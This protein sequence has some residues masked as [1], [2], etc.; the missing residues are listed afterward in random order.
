[1]A[2]LLLALLPL[3]ACHSS[4]RRVEGEMAA[5][6]A[7]A[8]VNNDRISYDEF[9]R[10]Y[11]AFLTHW[12]AF[13]LEEPQRKQEL[14]ELVLKQMI[15]ERLLDQEARRQGI[16]ISDA[17]VRTQIQALVSPM[18]ATDVR[19][20]AERAQRTFQDWVR[21]YQQR[22]VHQK[23]VQQEV[24]D[25]IN[26]PPR[27]VRDY[28]D[29]HLKQFFRPEQVHVRHIA[30]SNK[31]QYDRV[32]KALARGEDFLQMVRRY[33]ITPDKQNDGDLGFISRGM[34]P[35]QLEQAIF[36]QRR[37]GAITSTS[38]PV[39]SD[40][41]YHIFRIEGTRPAGTRSFE[42]AQADVRE[43]LV[44]QRQ[45]DVYR[46]WLEKLNDNATITIDSVLLNSENG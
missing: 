26:I 38:R 45:P 19:Q 33:S 22:L 36:E 37:V 13:P 18:E 27:E 25:K 41:G 20:S 10:T 1:M 34:L 23:L 3:T 35:P 4:E 28:Y 30:V 16:T 43:I 5:L 40:L 11:Q 2:V 24:L 9:Q 14:R 29:K 31:D 7:V 17:E 15:Q 46:R 32:I 12:S 6:N 8:V 44:Q 42:D 39:Q 21:E